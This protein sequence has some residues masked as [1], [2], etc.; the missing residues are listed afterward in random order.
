MTSGETAH[1]E[2][3]CSFSGGSPGN[4]SHEPW[5][6]GTTTV[7]KAYPNNSHSKREEKNQMR[8]RI[9]ITETDYEKLRR[10]IAGR[11]S[12]G[13]DAEHLNELEQELERAEVLAD[14]ETIPPDVV[15]MNSEVRLMD[16]DSGDTKVYKLVFP[17]QARTE[18]AVSVLAPIGTAILGYRV[19][20]V[21]EWRVP[22]GVRRLKILEV[23]F[24]PEAAG[25]PPGEVPAA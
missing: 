24:Q 16:L 25:P 6:G 20:S 13:A 10:L 4:A 5:H 21:I 17:S 14:N 8:D 12:G 2:R 22:K 1:K 18:N 3:R 19:G 15:T 11:R 7:A 23:L 9:F